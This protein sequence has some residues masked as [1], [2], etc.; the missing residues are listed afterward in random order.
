MLDIGWPEL[1]VVAVVLIVVVGPK[2][3][4]RMLRAFGKATSRMRS[5]ANEFRG[6][7]DEAM[8]EAELDD[9]RKT[10]ADAQKLNPTK[11]LR[12]AM[13]PLRK[14]G[15]D[16]RASLQDATRTPAKPKASADQANGGVSADD[17]ANGTD[18]AAESGQP[19]SVGVATAASRP[20]SAEHE[21]AGSATS[22]KAAPSGRAAG[23]AAG[24]GGTDGSRGGSR[25]A[26]SR[27]PAG[28]SKS[29]VGKSKKSA[30]ANA[31]AGPSR[32][33]RSGASASRQSAPD[34]A[35]PVPSRSRK[36]GPAK[37]AKAT[38]S[39]TASRPRKPGATRA[40][41]KTETDDA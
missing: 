7:F 21:G 36:T 18:K 23:N 19:S 8:K 1:F 15:D 16:I 4:P 20:A 14:A 24:R 5:M 9:V 2:D 10:I 35:K 39:G 31:A 32:S 27:S 3:L 33:G 40:G 12:E 11:S 22:A 38:K 25:T 34:A 30:A 6:Q 13:N 29:S 26:A 28:S 37:A 17:S 41:K